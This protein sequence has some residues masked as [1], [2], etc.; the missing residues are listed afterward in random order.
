MSGDNRKRLYDSQKKEMVRK[1]AIHTKKL[2]QI[3]QEVKGLIQGEP[4]VLI[5]Y[6]IIFAKEIYSKE[7]KYKGSALLNEVMILETKWEMRG[8]NP[9]VLEAIKR[10]YVYGYTYITPFRLDISLLDGQHILS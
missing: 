1:E 4:L 8:L 2:V 10:F 9:I 7:N 6:Y 3:E 5:P